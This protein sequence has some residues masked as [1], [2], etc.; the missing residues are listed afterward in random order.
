MR[1]LYESGLLGKRK[2]TSTRNSSD[3]LNES[4]GKKR[5]KQKAEIIPGLK[6][7]KFYPIKI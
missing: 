2:Y 5:K 7:Q 4:G 6:C 1:V 3:F